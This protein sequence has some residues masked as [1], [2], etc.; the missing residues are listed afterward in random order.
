MLLCSTSVCPAGAAMTRSMV[1]FLMIRPPPRSTLFPYT[2]LFRSTLYK[3]NVSWHPERPSHD[4]ET[5][6]VDFGF[7]W[8]TVEG[9]GHDAMFRFNGRRIRLYTSISWG[10]WALNGL[11]PIPELAEKEVR[12]AKSLNL[13]TLN[14]HRNLAK[15]DVL[16][17]QDRVGLLRC[18]EPGRS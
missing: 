13:N 3:L 15:E 14:F 1:F 18:L 5:R 12:V 10:F 8:F 11:F 6:E 9:L 7:R 4:V 16:Y 17:I 2:T